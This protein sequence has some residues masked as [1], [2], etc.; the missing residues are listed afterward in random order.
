MNKIHYLMNRE[1]NYT[2]SKC[3]LT[4]LTGREE[5]PL[6]KTDACGL[7][8][9]R[10]NNDFTGL[11][12]KLVLNDIE[13]LT[14]AHIHLGMRGENGQI[15]AFLFGPVT[16]G[17][18]VNRGVVTGIIVESDLTGPL[19]GISLLDL[20]RKMEIGNS[21]VNAHTENHPNGEIRGQ[22]KRF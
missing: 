18:S 4:R 13:I 1:V 3:F 2:L 17:I 16:S 20:A 7:V 22:I 9:F 10:F 15:V 12:F 11:R 14:A 19:Q 5:V 21:Y 6:V 8:L